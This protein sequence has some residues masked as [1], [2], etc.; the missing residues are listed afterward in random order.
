PSCEG[1]GR[2]GIYVL[3]NPVRRDRPRYL[4]HRPTTYLERAL[5]GQRLAAGFDLPPEP[6][7]DLILRAAE[8]EAGGR[9]IRGG[10]H[11]SALQRPRDRAVG[12]RG[13]VVQPE[14]PRPPV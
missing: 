10:P 8:S 9:A 14:T 7:S 2:R 1:I 13:H 12:R 11:R 4:K 6:L 5:G 3:H